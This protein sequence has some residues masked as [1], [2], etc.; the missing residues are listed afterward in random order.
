MSILKEGAS[1]D[2]R[3]LIIDGTWSQ[4]TLEWI[5]SVEDGRII[6]GQEEESY[7]LSER[8]EDLNKNEFVGVG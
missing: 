6:F 7:F 3:E 1:K 2:E 5:V 8:K 4:S